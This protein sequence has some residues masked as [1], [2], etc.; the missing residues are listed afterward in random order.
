MNTKYKDF[1][2]EKVI[3]TRWTCNASQRACGTIVV[4]EGS[5]RTG[6]EICTVTP[7]TLLA[8]A[9]R[10]SGACRLCRTDVAIFTLR[11]PDGCPRG[12]VACWT[13]CFSSG[14]GRD[15]W[16]G[17]LEKR[18]WKRELL[19]YKDIKREEKGEG[20]VGKKGRRMKRNIG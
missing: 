7:T 4:V 6:V 3:L 15:K 11:A 2:K 1:T 5:C 9:T 10:G 16:T 20:K 18:R 12:V 17:H 14:W 13:L 8:A 19:C